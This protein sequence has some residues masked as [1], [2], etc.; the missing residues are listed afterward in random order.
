MHSSGEVLHKRYRIIRLLGKGGLS[1]VYEAVDLTFSR[2]CAL[3]E[4]T[5]RES[6]EEEREKVR[7]HFTREMKMLSMLS[8]PGLPQII[9]SFSFEGKDIIALELIEGKTLEELAQERQEPFPEEQVLAW[10][11]TILDILDYLH[12]QNPPV[13]YRDLKPQNI[14]ITSAGELR[15]ID[16]GIA[17]LF[18]PVKEQDTVFMGTPGFASPEQF[19]RSQS[20]GRSDMYSLGAL[21]HFLLTLKD[22]GLRPFDFEPLSLS[23]PT[24]ST[25]IEKVVQKALEIK[26]DNRFQS[27]EEMRKVLLGELSF[28]ELS[29]KGFII[30]NPKEVQLLNLKPGKENAAEISVR[31][32]RESRKIKARL[33][34][35]HPGLLI[36]PS[37]FEGEAATIT[38]RPE[39]RKFRRGRKTESSITLSTESSK[40]SIPV[41]VH[42]EPTLLGKIPRGYF[43]I[44]GF[45]FPV[46][47]FVIFYEKIEMMI[48]ASPV[49]CLFFIIF[50]GVIMGGIAFLP[51]LRKKELKPAALAWNITLALLPFIFIYLHLY[52]LPRHALS[53]YDE[54]KLR[55]GKNIRSICHKVLL[56]EPDR[57]ALDRLCMEGDHTSLLFIIWAKSISNRRPQSYICDESDCC[58]SAISWITNQKV[59]DNS[60]EMWKWYWKNRNR[61]DT[62]LWTEGFR[63]QGYSVSLKGGQE[64]IDRLLTVLGQKRGIPL[65]WMIYNGC[66]LLEHF[67][68]DEVNERVNRAFQ[69]GTDDE[70]AGAMHYCSYLAFRLNQ[71]A[72]RGD[73]AGFT[74]LLRRSEGISII[75]EYIS[76][77]VTDFCGYI[78]LDS[79]FAQKATLLHQA[80][81]RDIAAMLIS[82]GHQV[83]A[84]DWQGDTP[85]HYA[86]RK[87]NADMVKYLL[88]KGAAVDVRDKGGYTPLAMAS[89]S[90]IVRLLIEHGANVNAKCSS[91]STALFRALQDDTNY[92]QQENWLDNFPEALLSSLKKK[93]NLELIKLL[94]SKG[95]NVNVNDR[96]NMGRTPLHITYSHEIFRRLIDLGADVNIRNTDGETPLHGAVSARNAKL[97]IEHGADV[98]ARDRKGRTPLHNSPSAQIAQLLIAHGADVNAR[99]N[100]GMTPLFQM[101]DDLIYAKRNE[102]LR[103]AE[104]L[105]ANGA[106]VNI[107]DLYG[108]TP[109][110]CAQFKDYDGCSVLRPFISLLKKHGARENV[111]AFFDAIEKKNTGEMEKLLKEDLKLLNCRDIHNNTPLFA[112]AVVKNCR[113]V[114]FL[115]DRGA[116]QRTVR[117]RVSPL[118]VAVAKN[119]MATAELLISRS[120]SPAN[121]SDYKD[122]LLIAITDGH[123]DMALLLLKSGAD[124]KSGH[125]GSVTPLH[126]ASAKGNREILE[127]LVSRGADI[128]GRDENGNTP[129]HNAAEAGIVDTAGFLIANGADINA[130]DKNVDTPYLKALYNNKSDMAEFLLSKGADPSVTGKRNL[131]LLH[132]A[133]S[134]GY[135]QIAAFLLSKRASVD[136]RDSSGWT[137]LHWA[138]YKGHA[139][140][141][142][143]LLKH[144]A[145]PNAANES[146]ETPLLCALEKENKEIE[147]LLRAAGAVNPSHGLK[148]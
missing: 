15:F 121:R 14:M 79:V 142:K 143:L 85:L 63:A 43:S 71:E 122:L 111:F 55:S 8:H 49:D 38:V 3:K 135:L 94:L 47:M 84:K 105:I 87:E 22:P 35:E 46:A 75:D 59:D 116:E 30:I 34:S 41:T 123:C 93:K 86:V 52:I 129:L 131:P 62:E 76:G 80:A 113:I 42:Y 27:A 96:C 107:K 74:E 146:G 138:T 137:P 70:K 119:D 117:N 110:S 37:S 147:S 91:G 69:S 56:W 133:A 6:G 68:R 83:E 16:F 92:N 78:Q 12:R 103:I 118:Q 25:H 29:T 108:R 136:A 73:T 1:H 54:M 51:T 2:S 132:E 28:D 60:D 26:P 48:N 17:R 7:E 82:H 115:L 65:E 99:D 67:N 148:Q 32:S 98:S 19:R 126:L 58:R 44:L 134:N 106:D 101:S 4:F 11:I 88:D 5:V 21:M 130:K 114:E 61:S 125:S 128:N 33:T 24:V 20:D 31:S 127:A 77:K 72:M 57:G 139:A 145:D 9:D 40:I 45:L 140:V 144:R 81:N 109:L 23:N 141:V 18:N 102:N 100:E 120:K 50:Y 95:A 66:R 124:L 104:L 53:G 36:E 112:A 89:S 39:R 90:E 13:I 97:L 10:S 64:S